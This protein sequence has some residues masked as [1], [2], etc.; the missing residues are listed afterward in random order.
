M[1]DLHLH[2]N[3]S[4][5][6]DTPEELAMRC[7]EAG[8]SVFAVTDHDTTAGWIAAERA[9]SDHGLAFVRGVEITAVLDG[10]D[11]HVLGYFPSGSVP[12][13]DEFLE[14]QRQ[15]RVS[16]VYAIAERLESLG[17]SI[18][19]DAVLRSGS[20]TG[21]KSVGRPRI[22]D[23]L[24]AAGY[25]ASRDEAF[26]K[27]LATGCAAF[28]PRT[29]AAP[30]EVVE[31]IG[32]CGGIASLAHPGLLNRDDQLPSLI[33]A[34]MPAIEVFHS[35]HDEETRQRYERLARKSG[36]LITGGSDYHGPTAGHGELGSVALPEEHYHALLDRLVA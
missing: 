35:D 21:G 34:G 31:L 25:V 8:I 36:L 1:I 30:S 19:V 20:R 18:D 5:G 10:R 26:R 13:L 23:A 9:A 2:T 3:V 22:A 12:M 7:R 6:Q 14:E 11:V 27:Y 4:D 29:G 33:L 28:V 24:I 32:C 16:R 17:C 15:H